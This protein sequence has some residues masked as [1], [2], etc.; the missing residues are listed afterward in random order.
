M[1]DRTCPVCEGGGTTFMFENFCDCSLCEGEGSIPTRFA[2]YIEKM[3]EAQTSLY[4]VAERDRDAR[5]RA[6]EAFDLVSPFVAK[7][8]AAV[9]HYAG[10]TPRYP[11]SM[12][13]HDA[14]P[15]Y[16]P[17]LTST[18]I[19]PCGAP[20]EPT[21]GDLRRLSDAYSAALELRAQPPSGEP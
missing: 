20:K 9:D 14:E 19:P 4:H 8:A 2:D 18:A 1:G 7:F 5:Q 17:A 6:E 11:G 13:K 12:F 21:L 16:Q 10:G 3:G 15:D